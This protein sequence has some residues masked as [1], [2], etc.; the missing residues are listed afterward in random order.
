MLNSWRN[1]FVVVPLVGAMLAGCD[2]EPV[3][4]YV[5][6]EPLHVTVRISVSGTKA[7]VGEELTLHA[8]RLYAG[9]WKEVK[10]SSLPEDACWMRR[11][12]PEKEDEVADNIRW[13]AEPEGSAKFNLGLRPDHTRTVVF[14]APGTYRIRASSAV[15]CGPSVAAVP[16][17]LVVEIRAQ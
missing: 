12:P 1:C 7:V 13:I 8:E 14:A 4:V 5:P 10:R 2:A 17:A 15:W 11:P 9:A 6:A 3:T 16:E